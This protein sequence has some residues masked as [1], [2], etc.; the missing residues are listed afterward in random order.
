MVEKAAKE[1]STSAGMHKVSD[2]EGYGLRPIV[3]Y[4]TLLNK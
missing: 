2:L 1:L 4:I 3:G